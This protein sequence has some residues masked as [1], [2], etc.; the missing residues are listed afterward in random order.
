VVVAG[1]SHS[2]CSVSWAGNAVPCP[3]H[4]P[5]DS[6]SLGTA[7]LVPAEAVTPGV[8]CFIPS[9][10]P[11]AIYHYGQL[12]HHNRI[13]LSGIKFAAWEKILIASGV[14]KWELEWFVNGRWELFSGKVR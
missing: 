11:S 8:R 10:F 6:Q 1:G 4:H 13:I 12:H 3:I 9:P 2:D 5:R 7:R 14:R